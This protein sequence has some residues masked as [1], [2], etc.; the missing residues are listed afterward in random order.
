MWKTVLAGCQSKNSTGVEL[1]ESS[2]VDSTD[3][4]SISISLPKTKSTR[5]TH[6]MKDMNS[7]PE[8]GYGTLSAAV[9]I[10]TL[11]MVLLLTFSYLFLTPSR[12]SSIAQRFKRRM[13]QRQERREQRKK[14][15][16]QSKRYVPSRKYIT[17]DYPTCSKTNASIYWV[18]RYY[19]S[20]YCRNHHVENIIGPTTA[21]IEG[22]MKTCLQQ[23][24]ESQEDDNSKDNEGGDIVTVTE[25]LMR[26]N[27][28]CAICL[29]ELNQ[30]IVKQESQSQQH[31]IGLKCH[32]VFCFK[33]LANYQLS[34]SVTTCPRVSNNVNAAAATANTTNTTTNAQENI[35]SDRD[36]IEWQERQNN[37]E[38]RFGPR[39]VGGLGG[40]R[41]SVVV[42][43]KCPCC[44]TAI[45][46][47]RSWYLTRI[48]KTLD[49]IQ[50]ITFTTTTTAITTTSPLEGK[51]Q[52]LWQSALQDMDLLHSLQEEKTC[53]QVNKLKAHGLCLMGEYT[54]SL[55]L[56][57]E[58]LQ[59]CQSH[60]KRKAELK[61]IYN[62]WIGQSYF[63]SNAD[64]EA[65][66]ERTFTKL[67]RELIKGLPLLSESDQMDIKLEI[68]KL[69]LQMGRYSETIS[70]LQQLIS[71]STEEE[72]SPRVWLRIYMAFSNAFYHLQ[73]YELSIEAGQACIE[74]NRFVPGVYTYVAKSYQALGKL[75]LAN[76]AFCCAVYHEAPWDKEHGNKT[77]EQYNVFRS[78]VD[79]KE[80]I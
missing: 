9:A 5:K 54:Q 76:R 44:R 10:V 19:C 24:K 45:P 79:F 32:H 14:Q 7:I 37:Q 42:N 52:T 1:S 39:R 55:S 71:D 28:T 2:G 12:W 67:Q 43:A 31:L 34:S 6:I 20:I 78:E 65:E 75:E 25:K 62:F 47:L 73:K 56:Y 33:C 48:S 74:M 64:Q 70:F 8:S 80:V 21:V 46:E 49:R 29:E 11:L 59:S 35:P 40:R 57:Q 17:C 69:H 60:M 58:L 41:S 3:S 13:K 4:E 77:Q 72:L 23:E 63:A 18:G 61:E 36:M 27:E 68:T 22:L 26:Q 16:Q 38:G 51:K 50:R 66:T 53:L 30:V 15:Q